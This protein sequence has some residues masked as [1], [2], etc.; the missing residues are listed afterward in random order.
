MKILNSKLGEE[1]IEGIRTQKDYPI[2]GVEFIDIIPLTLDIQIFNKIV[3]KFVDEVKDKNIDYILAPEA[4]GFLFG[5]TIANKLGIG[6]VPI[7]KKGKI[8]PDYV[9]AE[10]SYEKE[11]GKD[12]L[13]LPKLITTNYEGKNFYIIDDIYATGHTAKALENKIKELGGNVIGTAVIINIPKLNN[14]KEVFSLME[15]DEEE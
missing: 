9:E 3:E 15:I 7:R 2:K 12:I 11:Y 13:E 8:P 10:F 1:L 14:N 6:L 5:P 4:R